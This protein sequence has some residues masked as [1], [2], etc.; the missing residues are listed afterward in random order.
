MA[1]GRR[2]LLRR[3]LLPC[4]LDVKDSLPRLLHYVGLRSRLDQDAEG[5][6]HHVR[7]G[8][9]LELAGAGWGP[10]RE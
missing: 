2:V 7:V 8:E 10:R 5:A 6:A 1:D 9:G 4:K 3:L